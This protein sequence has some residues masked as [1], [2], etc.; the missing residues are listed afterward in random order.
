MS[1]YIINNSRGNIIAI[2]PDGSTNTSATSLSLI[3]Q[4]VTNYG[5]A[6]N[7]NLVYLLENFANPTAPT[8]PILGQLWYNSS[9]DALLSYSS[10][11]T[12][13]ELATAAYVQAQKISPEFTGIPAAPTAA[14]GTA[15]TQLAT[16]AFVINQASNTAPTSIGTNTTGTSVRYARAD[17]THTG[18]TSVN[19]LSGTVS[20]IATTTG[21]LAQFASTTSLQL[22]GVISD[23]TGS[24]NLVFSNTPTFISPNIGAATGTDL[25]VSGIVTGAS[26]VGGVITGASLSLTGNINSGNVQGTLHLGTTVSVS[27]VITGA[28]VVGGVIT[29]SSSSV[30]G[31]ATAASVVGGVITGSSASVT[32][33]I[34][35]ASV[36]GG[37]ITG[38]SASVTGVVT[39][40]SV[41]GGVITGS[42]VSVTGNVMANN[43]SATDLAGTLSTAAQT[44]ITSV[45]T[46][47]ALAVTGNITSGN[48]QGTLH[49]GNTVSVTGVITGESVVGVNI[50]AGNISASGIVTGNVVSAD[51]FSGTSVSASGN[52]SGGNIVTIGRV[53]ATGNVT[54]NNITLGGQLTTIGYI[55]GSSYISA[56]GNIASSANVYGGNL[57][58]TGI[59]TGASVVGGV[60]TGSSSS[61]TGIVTGV[62]VVGGVI[63]GSSV[64][65]TG[66]ATAATAAAGTSTT[67]LATTAFVQA[68]I[69]TLHP[70]GSIY[71][72]VISTNP[73]TLFG[74][75]TW[76]AFGAGRMLISL[77]SAN[78]LFD[79]AEETGGSADSTLPSHTHT[80]SITSVTAG[81]PAGSVLSTFT[82]DALGTHLHGSGVADPGS[83]GGPGP[84]VSASGSPYANQINTSAVSAGTPT[85]TVTS[86]FTGSALATHTHTVTNST[87]GVSG[88]NA[89]YPPFIAVYMWKRTA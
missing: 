35:G 5:T 87:E 26:V 50:T 3:G 17:H 57:Y 25:S 11:N 70:I 8:T 45:G 55:F 15:T 9:T 44:N 52:V 39:G 59:V 89:N 74:F 49:S 84:F 72:A 63:T 75:G 13:V 4:G 56:A 60:I 19:G 38:S 62:S 80:A 41:V 73:G 32:G 24:G 6:E 21:N 33:V 34:T 51:V 28:S 77:N 71:T 18:V 58:T 61:V 36:V 68:I 76:T 29:G 31:I 40:A 2:I 23:E 66:I 86:T 69:Q 12:W 82:G 37:V 79:T 27:G 65:V 22:I 81:T 53:V 78:P 54:A 43:V 47:T 14:N 83:G 67:Q 30:T 88:T 7:E 46:L 48:V 85:G 16:T 10:A 64:S 1:S 20:N 42:S